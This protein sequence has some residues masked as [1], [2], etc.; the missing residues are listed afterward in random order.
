[1]KG[2]TTQQR[3][4][5]LS[6]WRGNCLLMYGLLTHNMQHRVSSGRHVR[7]LHWR[8]AGHSCMA[9]SHAHNLRWRPQFST[10]RANSA[11]V[12]QLRFNRIANSHVFFFVQ[13]FC[14]M[15][16]QCTGK[17]TVKIHATRG[18]SSEFELAGVPTG[19][20][21]FLLSCG[22]NVHFFFNV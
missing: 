20:L 5:L 12:Q 21:S 17:D 8:N 19:F 15:F 3:P 11:W 13:T 2:T 7:P 14:L 4:E 22:G 10:A 16:V 6:G 1:M 18:R 9:A